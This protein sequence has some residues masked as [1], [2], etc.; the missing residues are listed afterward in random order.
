MKFL[1]LV[2]FV[3][4]PYSVYFPS[5]SLPYPWKKYPLTYPNIKSLRAELLAAPCRCIT[6]WEPTS[7]KLYTNGH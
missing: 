6:C 5:F 2:V 1:Q 4:L 7:R 3:F